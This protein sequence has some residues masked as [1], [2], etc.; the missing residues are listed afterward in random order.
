MPNALR[1]A[2]LASARRRHAAILEERRGQRAW[3]KRA[4][5]RRQK[6]ATT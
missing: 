1:K 5:I 2:W 3:E 6:G 4:G